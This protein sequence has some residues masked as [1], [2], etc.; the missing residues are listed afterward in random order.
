MNALET[1]SETIIRF[2]IFLLVLLVL[3]IFEIVNPRRRLYYSKKRRWL[4]N[5]ALSVSNSIILSVLLP[6]VGFGAAMIIQNNG[7]GLF[8]LLD[9]ADWFS[10]PLYLLLFDLIIYFQH[11]IFHK[12]DF[13][14]KFHNEVNRTTKNN[15]FPKEGISIYK[16]SD[17][18]KVIN[19][20][21]SI[22]RQVANNQKTMLFGFH[23]DLYMKQFISY[24]QQNIYKYDV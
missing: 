5:F 24:I 13:L 10:I 3:L 21:I 2:V 1:N 12:V 22:M 8:N 19:S 18:I 23:R 6:F 7:W 4:T 9:L 15:F 17:T 20:F 14:W 16:T 11:R